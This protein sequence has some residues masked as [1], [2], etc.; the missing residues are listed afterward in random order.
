MLLDPYRETQHNLSEHNS[1]VLVVRL[2]YLPPT[3]NTFAQCDYLW[4]E[5]KPSAQD[6][7]SGWKNLLNETTRRLDDAHL[8]RQ[9]FVIAA[10]GPKL[11]AFVWDPNT[12]VQCPQLT[13]QAASPQSLV[14][15]LDARLKGFMGHWVDGTTGRIDLGQA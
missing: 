4:I 15:S 12:T 9:I 13:I 3:G 8:T 1:K 6:S 11:M 5:C 7:P 10:I 2:N 14:W